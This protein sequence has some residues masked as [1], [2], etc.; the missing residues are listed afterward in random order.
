MVVGACVVIGV[1]R[2]VIILHRHY[3]NDVIGGWLVGAGWVFRGDR[4]DFR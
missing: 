1:G 3:P 4:W 2:S